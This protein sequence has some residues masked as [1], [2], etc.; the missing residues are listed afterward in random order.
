[1][2]ELTGACN[3]QWQEGLDAVKFEEN[4]RQKALSTLFCPLKGCGKEAT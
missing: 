1:V 2:D 4:R 3:F